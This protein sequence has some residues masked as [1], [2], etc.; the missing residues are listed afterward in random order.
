MNFIGRQK[1]KKCSKAAVINV[2]RKERRVI[3]KLLVGFVYLKNEIISKSQLMNASYL[4]F[5]SYTAV[6]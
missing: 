3:S 2:G 5:S 1:V 6:D 4:Y